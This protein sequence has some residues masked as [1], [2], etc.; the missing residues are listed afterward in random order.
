MNEKTQTPDDHNVN[1]WTIAGAGF[2]LVFALYGA[3]YSYGMFKNPMLKDLGWPDA[4]Y[5]GA[6]SFFLVMHGIMAI[7][8][9]RLSDKYGPRRVVAPGVLLAAT[10]YILTSFISEPWQ[11]YIFLGLFTGVG[12]GAAYVP[13]LVAAA[14]WFTK[15][16]GLAL[17]IVAS[18]VGAGQ[19]IIPPTLK[20]LISSIGWRSTIVWLAAFTFIIGITAA[21]FLKNPQIQV[22]IEQE[23][24]AR[25]AIKTSSFWILQWVFASVMFCLHIVM[26]H[27][28]AYVEDIGFDPIS[29]ALVIT[30]IGISGIFGRILS[31]RSSDKLGNKI[32]V[33]ACLSFIIIV[34]FWLFIAEKLETFYFLGILFGLGYGGVLPLIVK[35]SSEYFGTSSGGTIFGILVAGSSIGGALGVFLTGL[36]HDSTGVYNLAFIMAGCVIATAFFANIA[37]KPPER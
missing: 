37:L 35:I 33:F 30:M 20:S 22:K 21:M 15:R 19:V 1:K 3:Y 25:E 29:A 17:G 27:L 26:Q 12:M 7:V 10:G 8:L 31:G 16:R 5:S 34:F 6:H 36:I 13:P 2:F 28:E 23:R 18:G 9:G 32:T 14:R 24:S 4:V 11:L